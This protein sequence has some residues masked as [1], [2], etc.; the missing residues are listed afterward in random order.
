MT[1]S[2]T[3]TQEKAPTGT[4]TG[5]KPPRKAPVAKQARHVAPSRAKSGKRATSAKK[6]NPAKKA[7]KAPKKAK[8]ATAK[9]QGARQGSK[10]ANLSS[11]RDRRFRHF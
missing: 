5:P 11:S 7:A 10:T 1:T 4:A 2:N 3:E 8:A 9:G 6:P